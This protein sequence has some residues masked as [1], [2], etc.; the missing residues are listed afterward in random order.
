M[1]GLLDPSVYNLLKLY[2]GDLGK[3]SSPGARAC[4][5]VRKAT[6]SRKSS[7]AEAWSPNHCKRSRQ[8]AA[9]RWAQQFQTGP[10]E[11]GN[12][13]FGR[14]S[15]RPTPDPSNQWC[16][17]GPKSITV[18]SGQRNSDSSTKDLARQITAHD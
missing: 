2:G 6:K 10:A 16:T 12:G 17:G 1:E 8:A 18:L 5:D 9:N 11:G 3:G 15:A 13:L 4:S 14:F 7:F